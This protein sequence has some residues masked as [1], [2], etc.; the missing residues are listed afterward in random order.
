M[1]VMKPQRR[2]F[3][4]KMYNVEHLYFENFAKRVNKSKS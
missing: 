1:K 4:F 3:G 2:L